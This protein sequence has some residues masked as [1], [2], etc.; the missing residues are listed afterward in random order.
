[1][2]AT[3]ATHSIVDPTPARNP[4][5]L[6]RRFCVAPMLDC[7][8][9]HARYFMRLIT[10]HAVL[11]T[12]MITAKAILNG[13]Q[14]YLLDFSVEEQPVAL[15]LGGSD[16]AEMAQCA[17][18]GEDFGYRE[19]NINVGCPSDRV[20]SGQFG[21]CLM[22]TPEIIADCVAAM[23]ARVGI[24]VT[25]KTRIGIDDRDS[26]DEFV[27]FIGNVNEAG[28]DAFIIHAR[29]AW[30]KGLS[31]KENRTVPPLKYDWVY[32]IKQLFPDQT[33]ILN[34]GICN[35]K[36]ATQHL[37]HVDG[38]MVGREAYANPY[39]LSSVDDLFFQQY[40]AATTPHQILA[41]Y[42]P[43]V[44]QQLSGGIR[45]HTLIRPILGLFHGMSGARAWRRYLTEHGHKKGATANVLADAATLVPQL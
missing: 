34:G 21:A 43:Y 7:T 10:Q 17:K 6:D 37:Q 1:M 11:Y 23:N 41:A 9:R 42:M 16:P 2:D 31:P 8:D 13:D 45:L 29:K 26:F 19:I 30:L 25:V 44:E 39:S 4:T 20:K 14:R 24:P 3:P 12:E 18:I 33:F 5:A 28:C 38:I 40:R 15:Q 27:D 36:E 35:L 32:R 22:A